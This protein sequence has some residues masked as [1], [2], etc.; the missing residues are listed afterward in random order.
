MTSLVLKASMKVAEKQRNRINK[1]EIEP[2][3]EEIIFNEDWK[4]TDEAHE[5][6][7]F[8]FIKKIRSRNYK[9][10]RTRK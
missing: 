6:Q 10:I 4:E 5:F 9:L 3:F 2:V 7:E 1:E 8:A